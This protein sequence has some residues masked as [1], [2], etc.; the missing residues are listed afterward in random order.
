MNVLGN[1]FNS[2]RQFQ[3]EEFSESLLHAKG[4]RLERIISTGQRTPN[5]EWLNEDLDEWVVMLTG[6]AYLS[7]GDSNEIIDLK[8]GDYLNIPAHR[9]HRVEWTDPSEATVWLTIHYRVEDAS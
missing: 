9:R 2:I 4:F 1:I 7:F 8:P 3:D 5:G 6:K